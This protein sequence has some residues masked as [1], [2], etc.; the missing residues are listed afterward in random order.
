MSQFLSLTFLVISLILFVY[1]VKK[2]RLLLSVFLIFC[3][4]YLGVRPIMLSFDF[5]VNY[6][7]V[8][9]SITN[10]QDGALVIALFYQI[11]A[12]I[13]FMF[14]YFSNFKFKDS[15]ILQHP[16]ISNKNLSITFFVLFVISTFIS[17]TN[18]VNSPFFYIPLTFTLF[19]LSYFTIT[20]KK[21]LFVK[22]L[23]FIIASL[24][25]YFFSED[26]RDYL[27]LLLVPFLI[28]FLNSNKKLSFFKFS[29]FSF[30]ILFCII[31]IAIS[32]R[33]EGILNYTSVLE[34]LSGDS[35][36][37]AVLE[38]ET[39]FS[40]VYDDY[41]LLWDSRFSYDYLYGV[42]FLKPFI[43]FIPRE[44]WLAKPETSSVLFSKVFNPIFYSNNGTEPINIF[45]ELFWNFGWFA[46][47]FFYFMGIFY[48]YIDVQFIKSINKSNFFTQSFLIVYSAT[49]FHLLRGPVDNFW[50]IHFFLIIN[51]LIF[52]IVKSFTK[53]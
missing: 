19:C 40:I 23:I 45:G 35:L 32:L 34:K 29:L 51:F 37:L 50:F 49:S 17:L 39:D 9:P 48:K 44:I 21:K 11:A 27:S 3:I 8:N 31:Y 20:I 43:S 5:F 53:R 28:F 26:R 15:V 42:S 47:F 24:F 6:I 46:L 16:N 30:V 14:G 10:F 2:S 52:F 36:L 4:V 13:I 22:I 1:S 18:L 25:F 12:L 38:V 7:Y 33:T 41:I